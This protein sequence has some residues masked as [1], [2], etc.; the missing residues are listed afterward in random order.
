MIGEGILHHKHQDLH[1]QPNAGTQ[2]EHIAEQHP[3]R[4]FDREGGQQPQA[5]R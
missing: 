1:A 4:G 3:Q 2:Q 5:D